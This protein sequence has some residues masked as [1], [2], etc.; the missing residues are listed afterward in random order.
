MPQPHGRKLR[1]YLDAG[2]G[3]PGNRG[4]SSVFCEDEQE[5]TL[6][7][8]QHLAAFLENTGGFEV[9]LSRT[10]HGV[11][12]YSDRLAA[13]ERFHAD[14]LLSLHSDARGMAR[15]WTAPGGRWCFRQDSTPG[16]SVLWSDES[17][18]SLTQKR[19]K[20]ASATRFISRAPND[21]NASRVANPRSCA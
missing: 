13:A 4:A 6:K 16:F 7:V 5:H 3:A 15:G 18:Q 12:P 8:A 21:L 20:I 1:I 19:L 11:A 9:R 10:Q 14:V 2:H 17:T